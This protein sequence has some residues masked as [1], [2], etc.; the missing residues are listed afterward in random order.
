MV[1][2]RSSSPVD[3]RGVMFLAIFASGQLRVLVLPS[4]VG[5]ALSGGRLKAGALY[6]EWARSTHPVIIRSNRSGHSEPILLMDSRPIAHCRFGMRK[7]IGGP[8]FLTVGLPVVILVL[9]LF[10][11]MLDTVT[12]H[13]GAPRPDFCPQ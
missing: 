11:M 10:H 5:I 6:S 12:A 8:T 4:R 9:D 2:R 1:L 13:V 3:R 7:A